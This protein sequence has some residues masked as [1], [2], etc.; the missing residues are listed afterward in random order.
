M[1]SNFYNVVQYCLQCFSAIPAPGPGSTSPV[2]G[3]VLLGPQ[4]RSS[5]S[6]DL[7]ALHPARGAWHPAREA[8]HPG[9]QRAAG[10]HDPAPNINSTH[11]RACA[12]PEPRAENHDG[13]KI[14]TVIRA[15]HN[16]SSSRTP[17]TATSEGAVAR[18]TGKRDKN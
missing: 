11:A 16:V 18:R 15:W 4:R 7:A 5:T 6:A 14:M 2:P 3:Q 17:S 13:R 9:V 8:R 10:H 1:K 12:K